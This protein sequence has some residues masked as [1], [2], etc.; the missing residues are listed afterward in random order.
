MAG[1]ARR[2]RAAERP[3]PLRGASLAGA[4]GGVALILVWIYYEPQILLA[5]AVFTKALSERRRREAS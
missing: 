4:A 3:A 2:C 5:G 1:L